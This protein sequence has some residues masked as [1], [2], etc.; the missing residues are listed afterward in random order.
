VFN[1][2]L[3]LACGIA[4][5]RDEMAASEIFQNGREIRAA[6]PMEKTDLEYIF[7]IVPDDEISH[8]RGVWVTHVLEV[9][10]GFPDSFDII[11]RAPH[12]SWRRFQVCGTAGEYAV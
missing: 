9:A 2:R 1:V 6:L 5:D 10:E 12:P 3:T 7:G 8:E 11:H 4:V